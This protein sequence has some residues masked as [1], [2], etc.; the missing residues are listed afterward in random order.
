MPGPDD[1]QAL[2]EVE[3]EIPESAA[4][5]LHA[6]AVD[7]GMTIGQLIDQLIMTCLPPTPEEKRLQG[8]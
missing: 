1:K 6:A 7:R 5:R 2:I 3:F 8:Q 4:R